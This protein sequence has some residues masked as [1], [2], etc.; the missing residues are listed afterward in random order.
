MI[1]RHTTPPNSSQNHP[2]EI[3]GYI[4]KCKWN[5]SLQINGRVCGLSE[6]RSLSWSCMMQERE[7]HLLLLSKSVRIDKA[8]HLLGLHIETI[9]RVLVVELLIVG[10]LLHLT[11]ARVHLRIL[12]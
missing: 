12:I 4:T 1:S 8:E 5:A 11:G 6:A 10:Y 9:A 3:I 2:H 7:Q